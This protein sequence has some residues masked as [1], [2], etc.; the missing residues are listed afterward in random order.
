MPSE[1]LVE[2]ALQCSSSGCNATA[3]A[4][5]SCQPLCRHHL[6]AACRERLDA[7]IFMASRRPIDDAFSVTE[8]VI[9]C[10]EAAKELMHNAHDLSPGDQ[11]KVMDI[12][13]RVEFIS[14]QLLGTN[15][16]PTA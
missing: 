11:A 5:L 7:A 4:N 2:R 1:T 12:L 14:Q 8:F 9:P 10:R 6:I 16:G 15:P 13:L 3:E